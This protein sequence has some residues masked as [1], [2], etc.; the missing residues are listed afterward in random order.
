VERVQANIDPYSISTS[1]KL[2]GQSGNEHN[3]NN[4]KGLS[5][6]FGAT[7]SC[8]H[9]MFI[10]H[11]WPLFTVVCFIPVLDFLALDKRPVWQALEVYATYLAI[12]DCNGAQ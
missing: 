7:R 3:N 1:G 2:E 8:H 5:E 11:C 4:T 12:K 6:P 9:M 10:G